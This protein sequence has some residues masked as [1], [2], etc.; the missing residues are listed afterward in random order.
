[1]RIGVD[2]GNGSPDSGRRFTFTRA[3]VD[4]IMACSSSHVFVIWDGLQEQ[5][6]KRGRIELIKHV[7]DRVGAGRLIRSGVRVRCFLCCF[8]YREIH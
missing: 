7:V 4:A 2:A 1:M 3:V 5:Q 8:P 6:V